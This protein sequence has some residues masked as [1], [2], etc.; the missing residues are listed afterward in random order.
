[1]STRGGIYEVDGLLL[2][3]DG[4]EVESAYEPAPTRS[5]VPLFCDYTQYKLFTFC[6]LAWFERYCKGV[7]REP[8]AVGPSGKDDPLTLGSLVHDGLQSYRE[9]GTPQVRHSLVASL[10]ASAE[11]AAWARLL[12]DA[13]ARRYPT[14]ETFHLFRCEAPLR[15]DLRLPAI[16]GLAKI[17]YYFHVERETEFE[18]GLGGFGNNF[19]LQPGWWIREYKTF[20]ASRERGMWLD[21]WRVNLQADF[22]IHALQ[23]KIG[24]RVQGL[25]VD[26]LEKPTPYVPKHKCKQCSTQSKRA[27]WV[28]AGDLHDAPA[29]PYQKGIPG[30]RCPVCGGIQT[31]SIVDRSKGERRPEFYRFAVTRTAEQLA[32]S[33]VEIKRVANRMLCLRTQAVPDDGPARR[34]PERCIATTRGVSSRCEY[35]EPH[36]E[37]R[38]A[39]GWSGFVK[40]DTLAYAEAGAAEAAEQEPS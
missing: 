12:L 39:A 20:A 38:E 25:F 7:V 4:R 18:S 32:E 29:I 30:F 10:N 37:G 33:R 23:E 11:C 1:M 16:T 26:V 6:E 19:V 24:E 28:P 21:S 8:F 36:T 40:A 17:D 14:P 15:F 34:S 3:G 2:H 31:L 27:D 13:Y 9:S 5:A 35:F 22:Q